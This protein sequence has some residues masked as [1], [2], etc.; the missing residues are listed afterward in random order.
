M[1][2]AKA[3]FSGISDKNLLVSEVR[4]VQNVYKMVTAVS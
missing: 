2:T 4:K 1:F 3:D